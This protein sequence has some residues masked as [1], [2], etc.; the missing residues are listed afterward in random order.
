LDCV[1]LI[2]KII[3]E[4]VISCLM[5]DALKEKNVLEQKKAEAKI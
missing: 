5:I 3:D 4:Q 1:F 2:E